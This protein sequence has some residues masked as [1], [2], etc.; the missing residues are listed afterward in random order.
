[1]FSLALL[2]FQV[3]DL[4]MELAKLQVGAPH[5]RMV[6]SQLVSQETVAHDTQCTSCHP[7]VAD[8]AERPAVRG[9]SPT[10]MDEVSTLQVV[11]R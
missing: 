8:G 9:T 10:Q 3:D 5:E 7:S 6:T 4:T 11:I 2:P 1:M